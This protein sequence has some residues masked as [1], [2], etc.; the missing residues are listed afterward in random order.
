MK[1]RVDS[2]STA[3]LVIDMINGF[4]AEKAPLEVP[5]ARSIVPNIRK[6][7][8]KSREFSIPII[9]ANHSFRKDGLDRGLMFDFWPVLADGCLA[10]DTE[11]ADVYSELK[12]EGGDIIVRKYRYSAFFNTDLDT[13]LRKLGRDTLIITGTLTEFCC[14]STARDAFFRDYKVLFVSDANATSDQESHR[15]TLRTI[16]RGFGEVVSTA[17]LLN[18]F[19]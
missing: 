2:K 8:E 5:E 14:E 4:V 12:P 13:I 7:V 16:S 6:L 15:S 3:L 9:Y 17:E 19:Q 18:R 1:F 10:Q 11:G